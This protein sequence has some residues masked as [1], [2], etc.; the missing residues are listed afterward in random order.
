MEI[1]TVDFEDHAL[2]NI[3]GELVKLTPFKERDPNIIKVGVDAPK[4]M[5]V[6][7][8][9]IHLQLLKDQGKTR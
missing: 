9:E 6:N 3:N 2:L 7:R 4:S 8:E 5:T 1:L